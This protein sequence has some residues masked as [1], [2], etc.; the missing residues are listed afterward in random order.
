MSHSAPA[1]VS[2]E[3]LLLDAAEELERTVRVGELELLGEEAQHAPL[4]YGVGD[5]HLSRVCVWGEGY[6]QQGRAVCA[7]ARAALRMPV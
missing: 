2:A 3:A 7:R 1:E 4:I 6:M 5:H